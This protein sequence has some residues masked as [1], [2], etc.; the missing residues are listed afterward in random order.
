MAIVSFL[1]QTT[2]SIS[3]APDQGP[4]DTT[5]SSEN[6]KLLER[7]V[8]EDAIF[9]KHSNSISMEMEENANFWKQPVYLHGKE[10][11]VIFWVNSLW[12]RSPADREQLQHSYYRGEKQ[13]TGNRKWWHRQ[14]INLSLSLQD[15]TS[16]EAT[17]LWSLHLTGLRFHDNHLLLHRC[18]GK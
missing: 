15:S 17:P 8:N 13:E 1:F 18:S 4:I 7:W 12:M 3:V 9:W 11:K 14:E 6:T 5:S 10:E 2:V 16:W